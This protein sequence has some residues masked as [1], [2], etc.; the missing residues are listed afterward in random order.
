MSIKGSI[1][2]VI[3][4][5]NFHYN[6]STWKIKSAIGVLNEAEYPCCPGKIYQD[7]KFNLVLVRFRLYMVVTLIIPM[8]LTSVLAIFTFFI[9][10]DAGLKINISKCSDF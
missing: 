3:I 1:A 10:P 8:L 5:D 4:T 7:V 6:S 9:P 2:D